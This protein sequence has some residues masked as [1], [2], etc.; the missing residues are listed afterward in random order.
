MRLDRK[1]LREV[2]KGGR[3]G[4]LPA[5]EL[6][7]IAAVRAQLQAVAVF[8]HPEVG[9][10]VVVAG[11]DLHTENVGNEVVSRLGI[12][13]GDADVAEL[14]DAGH[15]CRSFRPRSLFWISWSP[16]IIHLT[17]ISRSFDLFKEYMRACSLG[18]RASRRARPHLRIRGDF[19][20]SGRE[21][22]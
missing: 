18:R 19:G 11:N 12:T 22:V 13:D 16:P 6:E 20:H 21:S 1:L 9:G 7:V 17:I 14:G 3:I 10:G 8:V 2:L 15:A 5:D 4:H